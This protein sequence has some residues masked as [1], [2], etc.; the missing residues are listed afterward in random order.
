MNGELTRLIAGYACMY[1]TLSAMRM[2]APLLALSLG[3][4]TAETGFL[5]A[6]FAIPQVVLAIPAGRWSD[7]AGIRPVVRWSVA[8]ATCGALL[9]ATRPVYTVICLSAL[10]VGAAM[11]AITIA[12]QRHVGRI[13]ESAADRRR[14]YSWLSLA[15]PLANSVGALTAGLLIDH[16]G[17]RTAFL[18]LAAMPFVGWLRLRTAQELPADR[19]SPTGPGT[20]WDLWRERPFR[21]LL[22]LNWFSAA[23]IDA[24]TLIVPVLGHELGLS[25]SAIGAVLG[26]FAIAT[27]AVR[28]LMPLWAADVREWKLIAVALGLAA[29][30]Y[31]LYRFAVTP[32]AMAFCAAGLGGSVGCVQPMVLSLLHHV[33]PEHRHGEALA[34]RHLVINASTAAMPVVF[35]AASGLAGVGALF[36]LMSVAMG[37]GSRIS[38]GLRGAEGGSR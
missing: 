18:I 35:G 33:T 1:A 7:R 36:L 38:M 22:V 5:V 31:A 3:R 32:V 34:M 15:P 4:S 10:A 12:L 9:T 30:F 23:S 11:G 27:A 25:A 37:C 28:L 20:A 8:L 29:L 19:G 21:R 24:H 26:C 6:L 14:A 2:A 17:Y 16:A 13:A